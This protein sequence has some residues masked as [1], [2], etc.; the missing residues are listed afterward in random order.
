ML[1]KKWPVDRTSTTFS[2]VSVENLED[3][4]LFSECQILRNEL[5]VEHE[6]NLF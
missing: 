2:E 4:H 3:F 1:L 5:I 6:M